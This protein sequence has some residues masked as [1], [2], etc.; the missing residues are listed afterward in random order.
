MIK[1]DQEAC[2][3]CGACATLADKIFKMNDAGKAEAISQENT[4]EAG[5]AK[6]S[7]PV[8]AITID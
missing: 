7:C 4:T 3:G 1:V 6:D 8:S 5:E 2:I